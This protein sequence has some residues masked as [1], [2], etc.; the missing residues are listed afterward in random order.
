LKELEDHKWFPASLRKFQTDFIGFV[1]LRFNS[2]YPFVQY[3]NSHFYHRQP[4][5]DL[6]SGSGEPAI[7]IFKKTNC[8]SR[9]VL[10]D[11]YPV[12]LHFKSKEIHYESQSVDVR[13]MEFE[14][15][16][17][18][19]MFNAFHHFSDEEKLQLTKKIIASGSTA[20]IVEILEPTVLCLFKVFTVTTIGCLLFTPFV[21]PFS[22]KR[23]FF[24][25]IIP[26]N[27]FTIFFDGCVSVFKSRSLKQYQ[28][29]FVPLNGAVK[30]FRLKN[31]INS[32]IVIEIQTEHES[33]KDIL[34]F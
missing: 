3:L 25:Y 33:A 6:C 1:V 10:T 13:E 9:L 17:Y 21:K 32:L 29:L 15:G 27:L 7:N 34:E 18:Y 4:V 12:Q 26:I 2:Y 23:I 14:G 28:K 11:K 20:F 22:F 5:I 16:K 19:T 30:I 24:T 31:C 8:F